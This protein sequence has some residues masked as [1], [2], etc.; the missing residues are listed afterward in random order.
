MIASYA[1]AAAAMAVENP[2]PSACMGSEQASACPQKGPLKKYFA[3]KKEFR[4][5]E[6]YYH[7]PLWRIM[8]FSGS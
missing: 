1:G 5:A 7:A 8:V 4:G 6:W 3:A 2:Q